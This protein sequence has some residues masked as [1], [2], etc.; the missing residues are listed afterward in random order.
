MRC[1]PRQSYQKWKAALMARTYSLH[2]SRKILRAAYGWYRKKGDSLPKPLYQQ[3]ESDL[4]ACDQA[5]LAGNREEASRLARQ[6]EGVTQAHFK[7]TWMQYSLELAGALIVALIIALLVRLMWWEPYE[8][9]TG[10][11]P[12]T[13]KEQDHLTVTKTSFG[14]NMPLVTDHFYFDPDLV[15]RTGIVIWSGDNIPL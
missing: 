2:S 1:N 6:K 5:L 14:I 4:A 8:I 12:P 9:P 15:Q 3:F 10:S 13:F 11:M 7:K